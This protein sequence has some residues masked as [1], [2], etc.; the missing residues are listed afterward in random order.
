MG[1]AIDQLQPLP[2]SKTKKVGLLWSTNKNKSEVVRNRAKFWTYAL[3][4]FR[5]AGPL[6]DVPKLSCLP[7][8]T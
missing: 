7:R 6:E 1:K 5:E 3:P 4:N 2:R 8:G